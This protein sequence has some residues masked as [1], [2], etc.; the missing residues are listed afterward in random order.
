MVDR[1][2]AWED[3]CNEMDRDV[4]EWNEDP[5]KPGCPLCGGKAVARWRWDSNYDIHV[6][7]ECD[8]CSC[9][10]KGYSVEDVDAQWS[11]RV[12]MPNIETNHTKPGAENVSNQDTKET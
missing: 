3:A 5:A 8:S 11:K 4:K 1:A 9:R 6:F 7:I 12:A 10:V 2:K